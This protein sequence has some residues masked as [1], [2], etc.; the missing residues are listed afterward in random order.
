MK[1][2]PQVKAR[3]VTGDLSVRAV[4]LDAVR[5]QRATVVQRDAPR[6]AVGFQVRRGVEL[7]LAAAT[8]PSIK[9]G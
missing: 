2:V 4:G 7:F 8:R 5:V 3:S 6:F 1:E 9:F